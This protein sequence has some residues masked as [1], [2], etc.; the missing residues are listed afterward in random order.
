M[1]LTWLLVVRW[2]SACLYKVH[3]EENTHTD[4]HMLNMR[5]EEVTHTQ[6]TVQCPDY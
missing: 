5:R 3:L 4:T 2:V 6:R 1:N